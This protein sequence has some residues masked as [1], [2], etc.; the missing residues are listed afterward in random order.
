MN[1]STD[2][3]V[4]LE[5]LL[6]TV[7]V[8]VD[9]IPFR[10]RIEELEIQTRE[11]ERKITTQQ[12]ELRDKDD[13]LKKIRTRGFSRPPAVAFDDNGDPVEQRLS[14]TSLAPMINEALA[15]GEAPPPAPPALMLGDV[16]PSS[17]PEEDGAPPPPLPPPMAPGAFVFASKYRFFAYILPQ[18]D[19]ERKNRREI[20]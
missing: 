5:H 13:Q 2:R 6:T 3:A 14:V 18:V 7:E 16:I 10:K 17:F 1:T 15:D 20:I 4:N 11:L 12:I 8:E 19:Q 9:T